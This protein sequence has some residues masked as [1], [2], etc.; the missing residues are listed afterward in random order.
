MQHIKLEWVFLIIF[1]PSCV[2]YGLV[3]IMHLFVSVCM[4]DQKRAFTHLLVK[5]LHNYCSFMAFPAFLWAKPWIYIIGRIFFTIML[6]KILRRPQRGTIVWIEMRG[7]AQYDSIES[8]WHN[9][10]KVDKQLQRDDSRYIEVTVLNSQY[11]TV[12]FTHRVCV[13]WNSS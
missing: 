13:L 12:H 1:L 10:N 4:C 2:Q 7:K 6:Q 3:R 5:C 11:S 9:I 8:W